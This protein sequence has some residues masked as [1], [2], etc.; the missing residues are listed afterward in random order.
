MKLVVGLGNPGLKY[1]NTR[2]NLGFRVVDALLKDFKARTRVDSESSCLK[3][4]LDFK[5]ESFVLCKP[6]T[7]MNLSGS[8]VVKLAQMHRLKP[9]DILVLCDDIHLELGRIKIKAAGSSG[10]HK[11]LESI[12]NSLKSNAFSRLRIGIAAPLSRG[13][14]SG[15]VLAHFSSQEDRVIRSSITKAKEAVLCWLEKGRE[16]FDE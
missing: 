5:E 4:K 2:H 16:T 7:F 8:T 9:E 10:G 1:K 3:A 14:L 12:I 6:L 13:E 11:G 15:Y